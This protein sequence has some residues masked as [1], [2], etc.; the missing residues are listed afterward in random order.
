MQAWPLT[1][2]AEELEVIADVLC[3]DGPYAGVVIAGCAG[4]GK[5]RLAREAMALAAERGW[6]VRWIAGT[7]AAQSVPL[8]ACAQWAD[9]LEG[10]PLQ[11]VGSVIA[12]VTASPNDAPVLVVVDDA[13]LLDNLSAFVLQ[14]LVLRR[15]ATVI[16][17]IRTGAPAPDAVTALWKDGHLRRLD[18]QPLSRGESDALLQS[19]LA[20]PVNS[21]CAERIWRLTRATS[22][23]CTSWSYRKC[24]P[25]ALSAGT[26]TGNGWAPWRCHSRWSI[27]ST[28]ASVRPPSRCWR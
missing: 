21:V 3:A 13:G 1:G 10:N 18:L 11:L 6:A 22:C 24:T 27:W 28:C 4:V 8:G 25:G 14:Q 5:T 7:V 19:A 9:R 23:S 16:A 20:R 2:R 15:A 26:V 17:T 12:K